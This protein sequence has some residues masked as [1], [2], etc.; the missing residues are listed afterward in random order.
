MYLHMSV[1]RIVTCHLVNVKRETS[2]SHL[3]LLLPKAIR[4]VFL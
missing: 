3:E 4:A 2:A 1:N